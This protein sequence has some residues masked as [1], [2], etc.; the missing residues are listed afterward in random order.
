MNN[1]PLAQ[2]AKN[3]F[4]LYKKGKY[5]H[6]NFSKVKDNLFLDMLMQLGMNAKITTLKV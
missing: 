6:D 2:L 1:L 5:Y 3:S 4:L